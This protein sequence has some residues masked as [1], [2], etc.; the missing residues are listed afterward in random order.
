MKFIL[1]EQ[2]FTNTW[3]YKIPYNS[4]SQHTYG[5]ATAIMKKKGKNSEQPNY[6]NLKG[7]Q[8]L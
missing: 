1:F 8:Q 4:H 6:R 7:K 3:I 5:R 2:S